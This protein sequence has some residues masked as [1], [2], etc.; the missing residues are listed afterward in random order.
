MMASDTL[1]RT[2]A[3]PP[4]QMAAIDGMIDSAMKLWAACIIVEVDRRSPTNEPSDAVVAAAL[5][6]CASDRDEMVAWIRLGGQAHHD[7]IPGS[8]LSEFLETQEGWQR[9]KATERLINDRKH[10]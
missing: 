3:L 4:Q 7:E 10:E 6:R 8:K 9:Q 2:G 1:Q 5:K